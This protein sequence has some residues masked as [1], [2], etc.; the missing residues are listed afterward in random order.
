MLCCLIN[1]L[2]DLLQRRMLRRVQLVILIS[3]SY[4]GLRAL[5]GRHFLCTDCLCGLVV[6]G[7]LYR[8][9]GPGFDSRR[10]QIF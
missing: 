1:S 8:S 5:F 2:E 9:R 7:S 4:I 3:G 10:F 6:R